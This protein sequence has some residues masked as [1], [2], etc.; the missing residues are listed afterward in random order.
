ML[1]RSTRLQLLGTQPVVWALA[2]VFVAMTATVL[3]VTVLRDPL[4]AS[5]RDYLRQ[6]HE[7]A[8]DRGVADRCDALAQA[9]YPA[10][11]VAGQ[12]IAFGVAAIAVAL[13]TLFVLFYVIRQTGAAARGRG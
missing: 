3:A 11:D 9:R 4:A 2:C 10:A 8:Y 7:Q 6:C 1:I 13:G 5:R 12:K